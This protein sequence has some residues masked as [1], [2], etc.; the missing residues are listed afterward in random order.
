MKPRTALKWR[1]EM[2]TGL[3]WQ[4]EQHK[5]ILKRIDELLEAMSSNHGASVVKDLFDFLE[6]YSINHFNS[7]EEYMRQHECS[8][9]DLHVNCHKAFIANLTTLKEMYSRQGPSTMVVMK[10]QSWL[11]KWLVDHIMEV[12]KLMARTCKTV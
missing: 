6:E 5:E 7:E 4:D 11:S 3:A 8:T 2:S 9:C 10:L 1:P 12:D